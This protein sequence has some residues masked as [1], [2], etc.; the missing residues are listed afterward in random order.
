MGCCSAA[1]SP[2]GNSQLIFGVQVDRG[3]DIGKAALDSNV[4]KTT[5]PTEESTRLTF[6]VDWGPVPGFSALEL[7]TFLGSYRLVTDRDTLATAT[8]TRVLREADADANDWSTRLTATTLAGKVPMRMGVDLHGRFGLEAIDRPVELRRRRR[9]ERVRADGRH[10]RRAVVRGGALR[11]GGV[12][13]HRT[14][15]DLH[16]GGP[17]RSRHDD[18]HRRLLRGPLHLGHRP[19]GVCRRERPSGR[20]WSA[21][22]QAALGFRDPTLSDR[23]F[24]GISG[25]G[26]AIGNP[27]LDAETSEQYDFA[28]R[29]TA[30]PARLAGYAYLYRIKDLIERYRDDA[31]PAGAAFPAPRFYFRNRGEGE[32]TGLELE[33]SFV[34]TR[35]LNAGLGAAVVRGEILDDGSTPN[36]IPAD[37]LTF[38]LVQRL[39]RFWWRATG[40]AERRKE[41]IGPTEAVTPGVVTLEASVGFA[42]SR[43]IELRLHGW[44]LTDASYPAAPDAVSELA[45]GRSFALVVAGRF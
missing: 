39:P 18:E 27:D 2:A 37:R 7:R 15:P 24:V 1:P 8:T 36:D 16:R 9:R 23:Y 30:G 38:S 14:A 5:Y 21:T 45:P 42:L 12:S 44:N 6:G 34:L 28:V 31:N 20:D 32:I 33:A 43:N 35:T 25:R 19:V 10:R 22:L 3:A 29:G 41:D 40:V 17:D 11:R 26:T 13:A 4:T